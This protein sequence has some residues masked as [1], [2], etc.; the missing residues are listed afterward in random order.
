VKLQFL[1]ADK[2]ESVRASGVLEPL[3]YILKQAGKGGGGTKVR[4]R[5]FEDFRSRDPS[6][7]DMDDKELAQQMQ[8]TMKEMA[9]ENKKKEVVVGGIS[10]KVSELQA[11]NRDAF[12]IPE[13]FL[14]VRERRRGG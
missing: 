10:Q 5:I 14:Y 9:A 1:K 6:Y 4:E 13:W 7:K 8:G 2:E 12:S 3:T 11:A